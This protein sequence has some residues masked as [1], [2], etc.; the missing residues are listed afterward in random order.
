MTFLP[1]GIHLTAFWVIGLFG[2]YLLAFEGLTLFGIAPMGAAGFWCAALG[3]TMLA[4]IGL[5]GL[6]AWVQQHR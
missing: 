5:V 2:G 6:L 1:L 3:A 4:A